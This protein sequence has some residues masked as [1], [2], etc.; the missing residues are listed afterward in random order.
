MTSTSQSRREPSM[1]SSARTAPAARIEEFLARLDVTDD[2]DRRISTNSKGMRQKLGLIQALLHEPAVLFCTN[3][4]AVSIHGP[5]E[6]SSMFSPNSL[7]RRPPCSCRHTSSRSSTNR[8]PVLLSSL[9]LTSTINTRSPNIISL[10]L[11]SSNL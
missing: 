2:A 11:V 4:R 7:M 3:R 10:S 9:R 1:G 8:F 5:F 6:P